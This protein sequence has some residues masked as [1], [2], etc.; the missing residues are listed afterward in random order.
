[1]RAAEGR[2]TDLF[3]GRVM[4][5]IRDRRGRTISFG[6]RILGTGQPKYVNGPETA[7]FAKR[8]VL[9]AADLAREAARAGAE[10]VLVEGYMDAIALHQA[11]FAGAVAPLGTALTA[12]PLERLWQLSPAPV[13]CFDGDAA[14]AR[15]A[16]RAADLAALLE[17]RDPLRGRDASADIGLRLDLLARASSGGDADQG[18]HAADRAALARIRQAAAQ[19]RRRLGNRGPGRGDAGALLAAAFPDRVAQRR[20]EPGAFRLAGGGGAR[21]PRTDPLAKAP[22]LVAAVLEQKEGARIRMAAALDPEALPAS[23]AARVTET[24]ESGFDVAS[25]VVFSRR[26]R[27]YGALVLEDRFAPASPEET[28]RV[29]AAAIGADLSV[30]GWTE[31]ARQLQ[32]RVARLRTLDPSLPDLSDAALA[33]SVQDWL[34]PHLAGLSR[35]ADA[36]KLD[37]HAILRGLLSRAQA[38]RLERELPREIVLP[39]GRAAVDYTQPVPLAAARAQAFYGLR[40]SPA[41]AGGRIPLQFAL[42]SPAGR[43]VAITT[44]LAAFW[45]GAWAEVRRDMRGRYPKHDWP[46]DPG[47]GPTRPASSRPWAGPPKDHRLK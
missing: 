47:A 45:R 40:T 19:Y 33:A 38:E 11:G 8:R 44:D 9:Y 46:E 41:L 30:L 6:G 12:E 43:P 28:A 4:F 3:F 21:L 24:V 42:L 13:L 2:H 16:A 39:G 7:V 10:V 14:G 26:R 29:L 32:A 17:E 15:A 20:G 1:M 23:V 34:A 36:A 25:G 22:L 31:A 35:L 37:L 18:V 5:P 27:R